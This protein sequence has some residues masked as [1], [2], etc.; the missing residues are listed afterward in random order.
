VILALKVVTHNGE[1]FVNATLI[2]CVLCSVPY[3][4]TKRQYAVIMLIRIEPSVFISTHIL[5][6]C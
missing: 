5:T 2:E 1:D 3:S 6:F 4:S